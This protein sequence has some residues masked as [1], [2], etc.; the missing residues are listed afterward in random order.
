MQSLIL[1]T[2][3]AGFIGSHLSNALIA[4]GHRVRI[5][6]DLST[7]MRSNIP[8]DCE[9]I[10]GNILDMEAVHRSMVG[11]QH[12]FHLAARVTIRGSVDHFVEDAEANLIGT[13]NLLRAAGKQNVK[14]FIYASS[15]AVYSDSEKALPVNESYRTEPASPYGVAKLAAEKYV[16]MIAPQ[17]EMQPV[18]LRFFNTFGIRQ[19][20]TPYV[21]VITIFVTQLLAKQGITIFG[22]GE[23]RRDFVHV[24]DIVQANLLALNSDAAPGQIFNVGTGKDTSVNELAAMLKQRLFQ[25]AA[26][27]HEPPR[28]EEL[29]NSVADVNKARKLLGY[30]PHTNL[31]QID[32]VIT[33]IS[34]SPR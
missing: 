23:Q 9:F 16:L 33:E 8:N 19:A 4:Q 28:A 6:D 14:R 34:A 17:F 5:L 3:G 25:D 15:M 30:E 29:R 11:A 26:V 24:S 10:H 7:G 18:V 22:D 20:F 13:L 1:V 31:N 32:E 27:H 2:G 12:V 21:G